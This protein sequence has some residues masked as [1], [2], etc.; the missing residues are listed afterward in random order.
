LPDFRCIDVQ[1]SEEICPVV[2]LAGLKEAVQLGG[3][4]ELLTVT[5]FAQVLVTPALLTTVNVQVWVVAG[6]K[7]VAPPGTEKVPLP[8]FPVQT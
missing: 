3:G 5:L 7:T 6:E 4:G 1:T 2:M 8:M